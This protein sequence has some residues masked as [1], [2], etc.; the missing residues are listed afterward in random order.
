MPIIRQLKGPNMKPIFRSAGSF[1]AIL[2]AATALTGCAASQEQ[3]HVQH[4]P[5]GAS[6]TSPG[7]MGR[8][9]STGQKG[10]MGGADGQMGM[11]GRD[12]TGE[13][14]DM[15]SMCEMHNKMMSSKTPQE[16]TAMMDDHMKSMSPEMRQQHMEMMQQCK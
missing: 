15:K 13:K 8:G 7:G 1:V 2:I 12:R 4:H 9:G 14:M 3:D 5:E 6:A 16:R 11:M 10:M